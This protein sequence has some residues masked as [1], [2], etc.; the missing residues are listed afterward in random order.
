MTPNFTKYFEFISEPYRTDKGAQRCILN[1]FAWR[2]FFVDVDG[3][4]FSRMPKKSTCEE[5]EL[6]GTVL[7]GEAIVCRAHVGKQGG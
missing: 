1:T 5:L 3:K 7:Q 4:D 2:L 6:K